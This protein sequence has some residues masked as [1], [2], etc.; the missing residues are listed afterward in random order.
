MF[1]DYLRYGKNVQRSCSSIAIEQGLQA[2]LNHSRPSAVLSRHRGLTSA[3]HG[4]VFIG[5]SFIG[6]GVK[7]CGGAVN[8]G[9]SGEYSKENPRC[10]TPAEYCD[11]RD[12]ENGRNDEDGGIHFDPPSKLI[13]TFS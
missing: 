6:S 5:F 12:K 2:A 8:D 10:F 13:R 4:Q 9:T 1:L 3:Q 11:H 7:D